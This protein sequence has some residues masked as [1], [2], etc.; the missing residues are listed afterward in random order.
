[1]ILHQSLRQIR[2]AMIFSAMDSYVQHE[3]NKYFN[4]ICEDFFL[5]I[6]LIL[7]FFIARL[8]IPF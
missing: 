1:M 3:S 7:L 2:F 5:Y 6:L 8:L 4:Y